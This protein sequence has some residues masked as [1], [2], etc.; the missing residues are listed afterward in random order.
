M[1]KCFL[2]SQHSRIDCYLSKS[3]WNFVNMCLEFG[4]FIGLKLFKRNIKDFGDSTTSYLL[5][6][7]QDP[8]TS[9]TNTWWCYSKERGYGA[10]VSLWEWQS[11]NSYIVHVHGPGFKRE[12]NRISHIMYT[13]YFFPAA[14]IIGVTWSQ[15]HE[16]T[17][18]G[19]HLF[20]FL[21]YFFPSIIFQ[22]QRTEIER[23]GE[24]RE[25]DW[26][27]CRPTS[28]RMKCNPCR[29]GRQHRSLCH[30]HLM[31][32]ALNQVCH[33]PTPLMGTYF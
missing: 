10:V 22:L 6:H 14:R 25:R 16:S 12:R 33:L 7:A 26:D 15:H 18:A 4:R 28:P 2:C 9:P 3:G 21:F 32:W 17:D 5:C 30:L 23:G 29:W 20:L 24:D 11:D 8:R 27:T 13:L 19:G 31:M 1:K